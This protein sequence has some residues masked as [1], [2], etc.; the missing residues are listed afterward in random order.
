MEEVKYLYI[1]ERIPAGDQWEYVFDTPEEANK[2]AARAWDYLTYREKQRNHVYAVVVK[3]E[4]LNEDA[5]DE[6]TG[7]VDWCMFDQADT[8]PG[9]FDSAALPRTVD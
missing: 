3:R 2:A 5:V 7:E 4:W 6:D 1:A 8:F 9:A